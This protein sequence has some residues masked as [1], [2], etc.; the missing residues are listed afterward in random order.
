M[1]QSSRE[2]YSRSD[3]PLMEPVFVTASHWSLVIILTSRRN[4]SRGLSWFSSA[5]LISENAVYYLT[6]GHRRFLSDP[7]KVIIRK[8]YDV[9]Q[10]N[11]QTN[12]VLIR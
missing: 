10:T 3:G 11:K 5:H 8:S 2:C 9:A 4:E 1:E 7:S 6:I 12:K